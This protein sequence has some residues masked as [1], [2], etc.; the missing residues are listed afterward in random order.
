MRKDIPRY[1]IISYLTIFSIGTQYFINLAYLMGQVTIQD[2]FNSGTYGVIVPTVL[3]YLAFAT[4][5]VMGPLLAKRYGLRRMYLFFVMLLVLGALSDFLAPNSLL[6]SI[7]RLLQGAGS[8]ALYMVMVPLTALAIPSQHRNWFV[9]IILSGLFGALGIGGVFGGLSLTVDAW[10]WLFVLSALFSFTTLVLGYLVLPKQKS[11][12]S[13]TIVDKWGTMLLFTI[14]AVL[15][16]PLM[17]LQRLGFDSI[18]IWPL[19]ALALGLF[20]L[21]VAL[22]MIVPEPVIPFRLLAAPK[23]LFGTIMAA[24]ANVAVTC[25]V[26]GIS[27]YLINIE[28]VHFLSLAEFF[29]G[30]FIGTVASGL[31]SAWLY[32]KLGAGLLGVIASIVVVYVGITWSHMGAGVPIFTLEWQLALLGA[33]FGII[34]V[35]GSLGGTLAAKDISELASLSMGM[36]YI[37]NLFSAFGSPVFGWLVL[38]AT[39]I[40]YEQLQSRLTVNSPFAVMELNQLAASFGRY[41]GTQTSHALATYVLADRVQSASMLFAYQELFSILLILSLF[42]LAGSLGMALTGKGMAIAQEQDPLIGLYPSA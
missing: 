17:N 16:W 39:T 14:A 34:L 36:Q 15:V 21:F 9:F 40:H 22:E 4:F 23:P 5:L 7:G 20:V 12:I 32:D 35:T 6:F 31:L 38:N 24:A 25:A 27:G 29:I 42:M 2:T 33:A 8:G 37:R 41:D 1:V 28:Q 11:P 10:R 18:R 19:F 30:F 13:S 3:S 26:I